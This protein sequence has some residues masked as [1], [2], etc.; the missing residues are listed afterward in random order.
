MNSFLYT[1]KQLYPDMPE[2][3]LNNIRTFVRNQY[4]SS[5]I[6]MMQNNHAINIALQEAEPILNMIDI[7]NSTI[8]H[9]KNSNQTVSNTTHHSDE[10]TIQNLNVP[11]TTDDSQNRCAAHT[12]GKTLNP[13]LTFIK[14]Q[15]ACSA[16]SW[17]RPERLP[18]ELTNIQL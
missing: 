18:L 13:P 17:C 8:H 5:L 14:P 11:H 16:F 7:N 15:P 3:I 1:C 4:A 10:N 12:H 2:D 9:N 6:Q